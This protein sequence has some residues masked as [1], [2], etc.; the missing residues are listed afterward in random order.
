[1]TVRKMKK[2]LP[3]LP[4]F[5]AHFLIR[6]FVRYM[7][8]KTHDERPVDT[9]ILLVDE[10]RRMEQNIVDRFPS[11]GKN[12]TSILK[13]AVLYSDIKFGGSSLNSS[14]AISSLSISPV[15][16]HLD[17][18]SRALQPII[19]TSKLG[20]AAIVEKIW[21]FDMIQ[22]SKD[23]LDTLR[24]IAA[25]VNNLPRLVE[26]VRDFIN[27]KRSG[28][29]SPLV[30]DAMFVKE[31]FTNLNDR[32]SYRYHGL[33]CPEDETLQAI[34]LGDGVQFTAKVEE[35]I[36]DS[37]ITNSLEDFTKDQIIQN[38]EVSLA[39]LLRVT[40]K[41]TSKLA[42]GIHKGIAAIIDGIVE[43]RGKGIFW[44]LSFYEW[45]KIRLLAA[46]RYTP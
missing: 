23:D 28:Q 16:A 6:P 10:A 27:S 7:V 29:T 33:K 44:E 26:F 43:G 36:R 41:S 39:M 35:A 22:T 30:I 24:L 13:S 11:G 34:I 12:V 18:Y 32:I 17:R 19:L 25:T 1:M 3:A 46:R 21:N 9:F 20:E 45:I 42:I 40:E 5:S 2:E 37:V 8:N 38:P 31:L 4:E 14:L 15:L